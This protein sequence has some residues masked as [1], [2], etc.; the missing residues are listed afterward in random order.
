MSFVVSTTHLGGI[1]DI[2]EVDE[3]EYGKKRKGLFGQPSNIK[4]NLWGGVSRRSGLIVMRQFQKP[5]V[6]NPQKSR[7]GPARA[8]EVLPLVR[9]HIEPDGIIISDRLRAYRENLPKLGYK[10]RSVNHSEGQYSTTADG[11]RIHTNT[12]DGH[13]GQW[14]NVMRGMKSV[15]GRQLAAHAAKYCRSHNARAQKADCFEAMLE[16]CRVKR[17][18]ETM[19]TD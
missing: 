13:W 2:V 5:S 3:T 15:K 10:W 6:S 1:D 12:I 4:I 7:F 18:D 11:L 8:S 9:E 17:V 16:L 14:K 19:D